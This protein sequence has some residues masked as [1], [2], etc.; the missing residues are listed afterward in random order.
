[1]ALERRKW[2][3]CPKIIDLV[4]QIRGTLQR[5]PHLHVDLNSSKKGIPTDVLPLHLTLDRIRPIDS[6][7]CLSFFHTYTLIFGCFI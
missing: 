3:T 7:I 5:A 1:M 2:S 6:A 4:R